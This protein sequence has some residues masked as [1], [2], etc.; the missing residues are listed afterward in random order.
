MPT[1][2]RHI[3]TPLVVLIATTGIFAA[4]VLADDRSELEDLKRKVAALEAKLDAQTKA[5]EQR[6]TA[7]A[8]EIEKSKLGTLIPEKAELKGEWGLGP[9]ASSVYHVKSGLSL[10]GYGEA[11]YRNFVDDEGSKLDQADMLRL[12]T[13]LGYK[14][15]DDIIFNSEIE[16]EHGTTSDIGDTTGDAEGEVS[17]EFAHLDFLHDKAFNSRVGMMLV[18]MG[19]INELHE[20]PYFHGV[21]RPDVEQNIIPSTWREMG[22]GFFGEG[23]AGGK[24]EYRTYLMNGLRASRFSDTGI[25]DSRQKGNR[26]IMEDV[27]WTSRL[28]YSPDAIS[29]LLIGGSG[30]IGNSGQEE[31]FGG[32]SPSVLTTIGEAHAQYRHR[33]LELRAL[34]AWG[35]IDDADVLSSA[36]EETIGEDFNGWYVET[37]YNILPHLVSG[38][39]QYVAPFFRYEQ[40]DT[41]AGVPTGF[42]SDESLDKE[43]YTFGVTYKPIEKIVFK[44]DY[45]NYDTDGEK[46]TADEVGVGAGFVF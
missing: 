15:N 14:F 36:L 6:N 25:R 34:G 10:G 40:Y 12:I 9:A 31:D 16:F 43:L 3:A 35:H 33:N 28:D 1:P 18:P 17:V 4:S 39:S 29:G 45:R 38:T 13:Y 19:F 21:R 26:A 30:W 7:L 20:P 44:V 11:T 27:A 5:S 2:I 32:Q 24:L 22:L 41:H 23:D 42:A 37:A 8:E 46:K